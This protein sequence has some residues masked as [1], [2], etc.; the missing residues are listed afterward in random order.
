M[1][2]WPVFWRPSRHDRTPWL[3]RHFT[4]GTPA[5][6][7]ASVEPTPTPLGVWSRRLCVVIVV[8]FALSWKMIETP[9]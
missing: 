5:R 2:R 4:P 7:A 1:S 6:T 8:A 9:L 3:V